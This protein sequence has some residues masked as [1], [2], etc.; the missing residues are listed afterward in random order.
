MKY[1]ALFSMT[2]L[3]LFSCKAKDLAIPDADE[4]Q[5]FNSLVHNGIS[6][7][8]DKELEAGHK[9]LING[10]S[11][12]VEQ[13]ALLKYL[14]PVL[15]DKDSLN[16]GF[17]FLRGNSDEEIISYLRGDQDALSASELLFNTDP[18]LC[19]FQEY[20]DFLAY[21]KEF[22]ESLDTKEDMIISSFD[23]ATVY[24][25]LYAQGR[26]LEDWTD[27]LLHTPL[28]MPN[29]RV[30]LPFAGR[31]YF[32]MIHDWPL[33]RYSVIELKDTFL[34]DQ[35]LTSYDKKMEN[36]A[37]QKTDALILLDFPHSYEGLTKLEGF[38][39]EGNVTQALESFPRQLIRKKLKPASY[40]VNKKVD[41]IH[42]KI[43]RRM[44]REYE[45]ISGLLPVLQE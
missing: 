17:W 9:I 40:L 4:R 8:I 35:Y 28:V 38:I 22:Y 36:T 23:T 5:M 2:L 25:D 3:L 45:K 29:K 24:F 34:E 13:F 14:I 31:L 44:A 30:E 42:R 43:N 33:N 1:T 26:N 37:G 16:I 39:G 6:A 18:V 32:M 41:S 27:L 12:S 20:A 11:S 15:H 19:G 10:N 7:Y 21:M